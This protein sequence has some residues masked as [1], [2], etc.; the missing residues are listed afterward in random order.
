MR[1][2]L[3][4]FLLAVAAPAGAAERSFTVT[5]FDKIRVDGPFKVTLATNVAPFAKVRGDA[6]ALNGVSIDVQGRTLIVRPDRAAWGGYPGD[7][8][9]PVEIALGTHDLASALVNGSG[10][11]LIDKV[12]GLKFD[13][14]VAG[15]GSADIGRMDV[16]Q[17]RI[18]LVGTATSHVAGKALTLTTSVDGASM[19][20]AADL[21]VKDATIL[22]SGPAK[23]ELT[24]TN[25]AKVTARGA[26]NIVLQGRP[27]CTSRLEG[28]AGVTG[29]K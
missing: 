28:S 15:A 3:P 6:R 22:S 19:L 27:A 11:L 21:S 5:G 12:R 2:L 7:P 17:L 20:Q 18:G 1:I 29:C 9:K 8:E 10:S 13:L 4:F 25:T 23:V 16:D 14:S 26:A 24:A